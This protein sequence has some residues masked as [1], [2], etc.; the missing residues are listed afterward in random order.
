MTPITPFDGAAGSGLACAID[1]A[2]RVGGRAAS[3]RRLPRRSRSSPARRSTSTRSPDSQESKV[4][5]VSGRRGGRLVRLAWRDGSLPRLRQ[6]PGRFGRS[7]H[8]DRPRHRAG[9][10]SRRSRSTRAADRRQRTL[11]GAPRAFLLTRSR[12]A[13][14]T[15]PVNS[16]RDRDPVEHRPAERRDGRGERLGQRRRTTT[17]PRRCAR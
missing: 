5:A 7:E 6:H 16:L 15:D 4:E 9:T 8:P 1:A 10:S 2:G 12:A 13:D 14:T 17:I 3:G 11:N